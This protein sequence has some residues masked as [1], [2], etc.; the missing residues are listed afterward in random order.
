M[1]TLLLATITLDPNNPAHVS[2]VCFLAGLLILAGNSIESK[3]IPTPFRVTSSI[4]AYG[5]VI[6]FIASVAKTIVQAL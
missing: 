5:I 2:L 6:I 4:L 3:D 1:N